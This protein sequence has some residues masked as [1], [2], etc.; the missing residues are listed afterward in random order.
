MLRTLTFSFSFPFLIVSVNV[1]V[2]CL[3]VWMHTLVPVDARRDQCLPSLSL[4]PLGTGSFHEHRARL[5]PSKPPASTLHSPGIIGVQRGSQFSRG[6]Q[7][8][9]LGSSCLSSKFLPTEPSLQSP[10]FF[11]KVSIARCG[12]VKGSLVPG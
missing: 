11:D 3:C 9:E 1:Y 10:N 8:F 6:C 12:T 2:V 7:R 4:I 5:S